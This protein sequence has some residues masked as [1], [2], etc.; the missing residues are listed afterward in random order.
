MT[1]ERVHN[2]IIILKRIVVVAFVSV[3]T[4]LVGLDKV[5]KV[6]WGHMLRDKSD[7]TKNIF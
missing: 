3:D 7:E 4:Q 2:R 5:N 1:A 6:N